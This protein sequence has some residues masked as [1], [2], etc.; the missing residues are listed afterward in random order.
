MTHTP[1]TSTRQFHT[2]MITQE[3]KTL[4]HWA[5]DFARANGCQAVRLALYSNE[6]SSFELLDGNMDRLQQAAE[7]GLGISLFVDGRFGTYSTNRLRRDEL[8]TFIENGIA[9]TRCLSPDPAR[10]LPDPSRYYRGGLPDLEQC[11]AHYYDILPDEKVALART[12]AEEALGRDGRIVSVA[13]SYSDGVSTIYR[14]SSNG[15]E[16]EMSATW[17]SLSANVSVRDQGDARPSEFWYETSL[18]YGSLTRTGIGATALARALRKLGQRKVPTGRYTLVVDAYSTGRLLAPLVNALYGS[19]LQQKDSFLLGR[20]GQAIGSSL[21]TLCDEPH[22]VGARGARYFD[23][24]GVATQPRMVVDGGV[25]RHYY[26]DTYNARKLGMEPTVA[27]PSQLVLAPGVKGQDELLADV[28]RGILVTGFNGGNCNSATGD[29]S[30]GIEGFYIEDG[31]PT[32]PVSEMNITGNMLGL[33]ASL[34]AV[35]SDPVRSSAWHVPSLVF[36]GVDCS[37]L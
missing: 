26:I 3:N 18:H 8:D 9:S 35:G 1:V 30:Y 16:G 7:S 25:L 11:D 37:G 15:F 17:F 24:E 12:V 33:W 19:A 21:L 13:S 27:S 31:K 29:F 10:A 28:G 6:S 32:F 36:E 14:L 2:T 23:N 4:A 20:M 22:L 34:A 5:M